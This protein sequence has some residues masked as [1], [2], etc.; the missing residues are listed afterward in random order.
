MTFD[1][2][3]KNIIKVTYPN[4]H[5]NS[6]LTQKKRRNSS[7]VIKGYKPSL[8]KYL[9]ITDLFRNIFSS[10]SSKLVL[11]PH[12]NINK[13]KISIQL[14]KIIDKPPQK[15]RNIKKISFH[16]SILFFFFF[17]KLIDW[18]FMRVTV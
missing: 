15:K 7:K 10:L 13:R 18:K 14:R 3:L 12:A 2:K 8:N 6:H 1:G 9:P 5:K 11:Y 4:T 17:F 16:V